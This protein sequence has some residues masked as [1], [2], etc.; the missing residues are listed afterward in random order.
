MRWKTAEFSGWGRVLR[1]KEQMARPDRVSA[2][3]GIIA[4]GPCP[5]VGNQRSYG[6]AP[7]NA[8]GHVVNMT[9]L[10]R[11]ISFDP[12]SG[13]L[14]AEA[15]VTI[16]EIARIFAPRGWIPTVMPGTGFATLGG[17]IANDVHGKNH[18]FA[19]SFGQHVVGMD[20]LGANG[21]TRKI[22]LATAPDLFRATI[23]GLGQT[24]IILSASIQMIK[25]GSEVMDVYETRAGSLAEFMALLDRS[26]ASYCVGWI[27]T[28]ARGATLGQGILE[29]AEIRDHAP[30][31]QMKKSKSIPRDAPS[32]LLSNPVVRL[33][34]YMYLR[35]VPIGGRRLDRGLQD[36]FFPLDRIHNWNRLYGKSGFHQ[37]QCVLPEASAH[38]TLSRMMEL[39]ATSRL[40]SPL[41]VLKRLG[42]GRG[43]LM[44]F[45]IEGYTLAVD[46]PNRARSA[47]LIADLQALALDA[48]GRI[49]FAK[50]S[51]CDAAAARKMYDQ[52]DEFAQITN[53]VDPDRRFETDLVR[54][55]KL[56]DAE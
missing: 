30:A 37:F 44:S 54:R 31:L 26:S 15:G 48:G 22:T 5:A 34:N 56:R 35:R 28:T 20:I 46:F 53:K 29:E 32:F 52:V 38:D 8:G 25:A 19:G 50:D 7:L 1:T 3:K 14:T 13:I 12:D 9:R 41:A 51:L 45:P 39:I 17:C 23:G 11:L 40:A 36:F 42:D 43:G 4:D 33:F 24:G 2:L 6:D 10:D 16:G 47:G 18:H 21:R 27:D 49:Y 55:L